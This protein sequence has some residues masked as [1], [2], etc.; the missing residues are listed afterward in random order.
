MT[1]DFSDLFTRTSNPTTAQLN[2]VAANY[3]SALTSE[4]FTFNQTLTSDDTRLTQMRATQGI[5]APAFPTITIPSG[6]FA[7]LIATVSP[8]LVTSS[9][10]MTN[11]GTQVTLQR[12]M[13]N[14]LI[15]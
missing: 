9:A 6:P 5:S 3:P 12:E 15:P 7:G 14:Y 4:G 8:Y 10:T 2:T 11:T 13:N 1:S